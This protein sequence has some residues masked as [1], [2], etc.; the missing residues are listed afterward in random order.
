MCKL[1]HEI[2]E[3]LYRNISLNH[4][5]DVRILPELCAYTPCEVYELV[6]NNP[7]IQKWF[8]FIS[9]EYLPPAEK[10]ILLLYPCSTVKPFWE[11]RSYKVLF[12]TLDSLGKYRKYIHLVT[13]SE[14][15]GLVPEEFYGKK[16]AWFNW[17]DEWYDV[18]GLFEW[19]VR[20]YNLPYEREY[21]DKSIEAISL[22]ISEYLKRTRDHYASRIAFIR[23]YSSTLRQ[24]RDHTHRRMIE[25]AVKM[26]KL[27]IKMLPTKSM[28]KSI[29]DQHGRFAW[30]MYGVSHPEAQRYLKRQLLETIKKVISDEA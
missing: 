29:V 1:N 12:K 27:E 4:A 15:F 5:K 6:Q 17:K 9:T 16:S 13:V 18:P 8:K 26:S 22:S 3:W 23:T 11:S 24:K 25:N 2:R 19:W 14:P 7:R 21:V 28:I 20:K 10:R 30:D